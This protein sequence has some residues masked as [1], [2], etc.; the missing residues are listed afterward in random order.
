[1]KKKTAKTKASFQQSQMLIVVA[2]FVLIGV[3]ALGISRAQHGAGSGL[4]GNAFIG[5]VS[6]CVNGIW[7]IHASAYSTTSRLGEVDVYETLNA[8]QVIKVQNEL[9]LSLTVPTTF[10]TTPQPGVTDDVLYVTPFS[11][12]GPIGSVS[13]TPTQPVAES[14]T[15]HNACNPPAPSGKGRHGL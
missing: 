11:S 15:L 9:S 1:M 12:G 3:G 10:D 14:A 5:G 13:P 6:D 2:S 4:S 8:S 7:T